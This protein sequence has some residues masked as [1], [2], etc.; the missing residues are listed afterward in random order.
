MCCRSSPV[1]GI[2]ND[3]KFYRRYEG[4]I[5]SMCWDRSSKTRGVQRDVRYH[6]LRVQQESAALR[7]VYNDVLMKLDIL[8]DENDQEEELSKQQR[9]KHHCK[10][11]RKTGD[12][13]QG[14]LHTQGKPLHFPSALKPP[15]P[16]GG[17]V[18]GVLKSRIRLKIN[19]AIPPGRS[20]ARIS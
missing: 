10:S 8:L 19:P 5:R 3:R 7:P 18:M 15:A 20:C 14:S 13:L 17:S 16:P 4:L 1:D 12:Q 6:P 9:N 2:T 11:H